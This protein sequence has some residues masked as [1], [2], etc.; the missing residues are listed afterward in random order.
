MTENMPSRRA[1]GGSV[2][3]IGALAAS[4]AAAAIAVLS[5][6]PQ[7]AFAQPPVPQATPTSNIEANKALVRAFLR[8]LETGD[9]VGL[10]AIRGAVGYTHSP[11]GESRR[12][13]TSA[14]LGERCPM[15]AA[16]PDRKISIDMMLAEGDLVTVR[17]T[18]TGTYTG[19]YRGMGIPAPKPVT[20]RY[21]NIYRIANGRIVENWASYDRLALAEQLGFD[22]A[23]G[24]VQAQQQQQQVSPAGIVGTWRLVKFEDVE[25]GKVIRRFGEKPNGLFAYTVDGHV[26]IQ[27]ANP[28]N[29][30]CIAP[31]KKSGPG[32]K[33]DLALPVCRP[34][35]MR[36]LID[37]TVAY[38]GTYSVDAAA[39][40]VIHHVKADLSNGY[41]ATDQHRP[42]RLKGDQLV[43]G[44]GKTWTRVLERVRR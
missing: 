41:I 16:L 39:G 9:I 3:A 8:A 35:Q 28:A 38:W 31:S 24:K 33:D 21:V 2:L 25:D 10:N 19:A 18:W 32:K 43:I 7:H 5:A 6:M 30:N 12:A 4:R 23:P 29:P 22:I 11:N 14:N 17:S 15:C 42:F 44:D 1:F 27:I 13:T 37:G 20:V 34:D 26:I 36:T 40:E